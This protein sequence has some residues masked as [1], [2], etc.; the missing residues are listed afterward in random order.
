M[1]GWR[2]AVRMGLGVGG[3]LLL[4]S[5]CGPVGPPPGSSCRK[6]G[7]AG[8]LCA[9]QDVVTSCRWRPE[10]ACYQGATCALGPDGACGFVQTPA[11]QRCLAETRG[12]VHRGTYHE[13][14]EGFPAGDGC[15]SC[16]C[17]PGGRV[18]C[19]LIACSVWDAGAPDG[20]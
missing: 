14:G 8:E 11:L 15:N 13:I 9:A 2:A 10:Y 20:G 12:C 1:I 7:C 16:S 6:T 17:L 18:V 5:T 4:L 19:T 3:F